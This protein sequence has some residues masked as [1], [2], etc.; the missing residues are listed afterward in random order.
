MSM[1]DF[2]TR[3]KYIVNISWDNGRISS[4][5]WAVHN[6]KVVTH[7]VRTQE[8]RQAQPLNRLERAIGRMTITP[9]A[10]VTL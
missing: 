1:S 8:Q 9:A 4:A 2:D 10:M 6:G 3:R 7:E 5:H